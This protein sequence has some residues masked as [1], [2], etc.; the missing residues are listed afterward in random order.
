MGYYRPVPR[1][2]FNPVLALV[3]AAV[4]VVVVLLSRP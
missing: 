3:A 2:P 4:L 1:R